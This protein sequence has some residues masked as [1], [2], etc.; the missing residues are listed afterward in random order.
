MIHSW[1][2]FMEWQRQMR[3]YWG[4]RRRYALL[5][6]EGLC[7]WQYGRIHKG[8]RLNLEHPVSFCD[9]LSWLKFNY[10]P[11]EY[12]MFADKYAVREYVRDTV[13]E[14]YLNT[15]IG[16]YDRPEQIPWD[17]LPDAFVLKTTNSS[18]TNIL[19]PDKS[20]LDRSLAMRRL[21]RWMQINPYFQMAEWYYKDLRPRII[22]EAYLQGTGGGAPWDYKVVCVGGVPKIVWVDMDRF[23]RHQR[24]Y[25][26]VDWNRLACRSTWIEPS[27]LEIQRPPQL[28]ELLEVAARLAGRHPFIRVD[29]YLVG[30]RLV[31]GEITTCPGGGLEGFEPPEFDA[32]VASWIQLPG[33]AMAEALTS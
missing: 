17:K 1:S 23:A 16:V 24:V 6:P 21:H 5:G 28:P 20:K 13:G 25:H 33:Q 18:G 9:K 7:Q 2:E 12:E 8:K 22:C 14:K 26:D 29:F 3:T 4:V 30:E 11:S 10:R 31:F 32:Q 15:L 27:T 19:C